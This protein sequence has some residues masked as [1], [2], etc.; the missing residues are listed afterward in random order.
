MGF[1][2]LSL[3]MIDNLYIRYSFFSILFNLL[4]VPS[5]YGH[6][7]FQLDVGSIH[8]LIYKMVT[9]ISGNESLSFFV[10][11]SIVLGISF[12]SKTNFQQD[13]LKEIIWKFLWL[14]PNLQVGHSSF[15]Q[16]LLYVKG[17]EHYCSCP[18]IRSQTTFLMNKQQCS[19]PDIGYMIIYKHDTDTSVVTA[20]R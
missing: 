20:R 14:L 1:S 11:D 18:L 5:R 4:D 3:V 10:N 12:V 8:L 15:Y 13:F 16:L 17:H 2:A 6:E 7:V 19:C 9:D